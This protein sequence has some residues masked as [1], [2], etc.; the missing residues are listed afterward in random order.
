MLVQIISGIVVSIISFAFGYL[1]FRAQTKEQIKLEVY[2]RRLDSYEKIIAFLDSLDS[3]AHR[4]FLEENKKSELIQ[5]V[6][7]LQTSTAP[8]TPPEMNACLDGLWH[9]IDKL[10]GSLAELEEMDE[11]MKT[12][13]E[14]DI[15]L[16]LRNR[17]IEFHKKQRQKPVSFS[18]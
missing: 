16:H 9:Y 17:M 3:F 8:Y 14:K 12:L 18:G 10:P 15:G 13:I 7:D 5:R 2:R 4:E 1:L 6:F 11:E